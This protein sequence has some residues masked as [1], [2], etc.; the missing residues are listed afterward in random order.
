MFLKNDN[1]IFIFYSVQKSPALEFGL[2]L[3][4]WAWTQQVWE[5]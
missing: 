3:G 5:V 2:R 1:V 4:P